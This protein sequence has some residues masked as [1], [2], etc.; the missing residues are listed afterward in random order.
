[1]KKI[2]F[3]MLIVLISCQK[4]ASTNLRQTPFTDIVLTNDAKDREVI[5]ARKNPCPPNNPH[6]QTPPP[7]P[8]PNVLVGCILLD[9]DGNTTSTT[10][11]W[12]EINSAPSGMTSQQI[13]SIRDSVRHDYA[14]NTNILV[15]TDESVFNTFPSNKRTRVVIT[16]SN[17]QFPGIGE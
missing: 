17:E 9:F 5:S 13:I 6:C 11:L 15:T 3:A 14:F 16:T 7:P 1:M 8:P 10:S 2:V 12:G 4:Q